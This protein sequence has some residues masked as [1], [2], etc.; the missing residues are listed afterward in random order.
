MVSSLDDANSR[1][2]ALSAGA[3]DF[4]IKLVARLEMV[5][6]VQDLLQIAKE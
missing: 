4:L 1:T 5:L 6:R 3:V 2:H